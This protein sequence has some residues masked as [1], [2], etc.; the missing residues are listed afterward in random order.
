MNKKA[1]M[2]LIMLIASFFVSLFLNFQKINVPYFGA[3]YKKV[4]VDV[5]FKNNPPKIFFDNNEIKTYFKIPP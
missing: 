2:F 5:I 4:Q 3:F 1:A